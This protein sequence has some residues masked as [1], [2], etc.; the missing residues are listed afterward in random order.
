MIEINT[1]PG[2]SSGSII[3]KQLRAA[4]LDLSDILDEVIEDTL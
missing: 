3:P 2:M 1:V 4:G